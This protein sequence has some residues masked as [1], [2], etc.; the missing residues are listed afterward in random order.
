MRRRFGERPMDSRL[1]GNDEA[2]W[3]LVRFR[4]VRA[5]AELRNIS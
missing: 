5:S 2:E 1:R 4:N 3:L